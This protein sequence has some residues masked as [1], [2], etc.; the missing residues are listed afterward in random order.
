MKGSFAVVFT[1]IALSLAV[2]Y[3]FDVTSI[4]FTPAE[5]TVVVGLC[6][7]VG[8]SGKRA[9]GRFAKSAKKDE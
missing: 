6:A 1:I 7:A 2:W 4:P 9:W 3:F 8:L 5:T